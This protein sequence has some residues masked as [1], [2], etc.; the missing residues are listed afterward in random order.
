MT[1]VRAARPEEAEAIVA[2]HASVVKA[3]NAR[4]YG[5][6]EIEAWL[7]RQHPD[8]VRR[9]ITGGHVLVCVNDYDALH[10]VASEAGTTVT[11]R[12]TSR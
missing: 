1:T 12:R 7:S 9:L 10:T 2:L 8:K 3:V 6:A 5:P 11:S 4:D